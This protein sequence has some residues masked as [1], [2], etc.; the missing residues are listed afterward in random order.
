MTFTNGVIKLSILCIAKENIHILDKKIIYNNFKG[1]LC[2]NSDKF[3]SV[4]DKY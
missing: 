2:I 1:T 4:T 3:V